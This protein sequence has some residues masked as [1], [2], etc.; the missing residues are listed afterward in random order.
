MW[1]FYV[2]VY[3]HI[4]SFVYSILESTCHLRIHKK[5]IRLAD[6][7]K[8]TGG[9]EPSSVRAA[10]LNKGTKFSSYIPVQRSFLPAVSTRCRFNRG[11]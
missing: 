1:H 7:V 8:D 9:V 6:M 3:R 10:N 2:S 4:R 11:I 5:D